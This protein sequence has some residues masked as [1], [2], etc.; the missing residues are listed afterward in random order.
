MK[1]NNDAELFALV[2]EHLYTPVVGDLLD[3]KGCF[4]QFLPQCVRPIIS[5]M[6]LVGRAMPVLMMDVYGTQ[7]EPFGKMIDALDAIQE[8][9]VYIASGAFHRCANWGEI[10]T[11]AALAHKAAGAVVYGYHRD[12]PQVLA[13]H[14]PVFSCG[15]YAQ[16]SAPRMK[17][18]DYRIAIEIE[19]VRVEPGDLVFGD[20]DGVIIVPK[21]HEEWVIKKSLEKTRGEKVVRRE[22]E[23]GINVSDVFR[24][25]GIL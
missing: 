2:R 21:Q 6:R 4:H 12:T 14:F 24:K 9:E 16:D 15:P 19:G 17:V 10:M 5:T 25:Y 1:W 11:A 22:I 18:A 3:V 13:Q 20:V 23:R 8:D 7:E